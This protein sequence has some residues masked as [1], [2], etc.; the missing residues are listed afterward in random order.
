MAAKFQFEEQ[1]DPSSGRSIMQQG[2]RSNPT[3]KHLWLEV[4]VHISRSY[5]NSTIT[6]HCVLFLLVSSILDWS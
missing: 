5:R 1:H 3:S 2:L 6:T 4:I